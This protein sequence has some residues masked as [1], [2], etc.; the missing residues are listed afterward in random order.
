MSAPT[1]T[2]RCVCGAVSYELQ[3]DLRGI[4]VCHCVECRRY[5]GTSGA[6]T[7]V[8]REGL[9][10]RDP[11]GLLRWFP[12]PQSETGG[13]RGFCSRCGS[14]LLWREPDSATYSV[15]AGTLDGPDRPP[16]HAAHLVL[17]ASRLGARGPPAPR[18]PRHLTAPVGVQ[19]PFL[20]AAA[21]FTS[22][23]KSGA[24]VDSAASSGCH[25]TAMQKGASGSSIASMLPS[26]AR[27]ET[28]RPS[29]SSAMP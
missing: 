3:G 22:A 8:A 23:R 2:G 26:W 10:L 4:L 15:A 6:Y 25:S 17:P 28:I 29:P 13:E 18:A 24:P 7:A 21:A 1:A 12:G 14:S 9:T 19:A 27:P 20:R 16:H 5:H 11:E